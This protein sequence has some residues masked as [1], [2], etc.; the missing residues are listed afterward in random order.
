MLAKLGNQKHISSDRVP[1]TPQCLTQAFTTY[2]RKASKR[3]SKYS[4]KCFGLITYNPNLAEPRKKQI[5]LST[6]N[7]R[8]C[9]FKLTNYKG[10]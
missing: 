3:F 1:T 6:L 4:F 9:T 7:P 8:N 5:P 2:L 10:N